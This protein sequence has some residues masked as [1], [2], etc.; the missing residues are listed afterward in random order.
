MGLQTWIE[1]SRL[2]ELGRQDTPVHRVDARAKTLTTL[3][4]IGFVMSFSRY[5]VSALTPFFLFP[6]ALMAL[7]RV[8]PDCL[9]KKILVAS[10]FALAVGLFNPFF[11]DQVIPVAGVP[12]RDGRK[13]G[14]KAGAGG[15]LD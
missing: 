14:S 3:L 6:V 2:D 7:G 15:Y 13:A 1:V 5:E 11:G 4:F 9:L 8:P 12:F 10:P